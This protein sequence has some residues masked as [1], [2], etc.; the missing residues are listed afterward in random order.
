MKIIILSLLIIFSLKADTLN[1]KSKQI[2]IIDDFTKN[3]KAANAVVKRGNYHRYDEYKNGIE[4]TIENIHKLDISK[5]E[6]LELKK[7]LKTYANLINDLY[8]KLYANAPKFKEH[9]NSST[10]NQYVFQKKILSIG[11]RPIVK[12]WYELSKTKSIYIKRPSEELE[13]K[14]HEKLKFIISNITELYLDEEIEE[15]LFAYLQN[16]KMYFNEVSIAYKSVEYINI[17]K[18]KPLSYKIKSKLEFLNPI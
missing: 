3:V 13:R 16:Y 18:I 8:K 7:D 4:S 12:A 2:D 14:F 15:P 5:K 1:N 6:K 9:Y 10:Y 17:K 11:Y